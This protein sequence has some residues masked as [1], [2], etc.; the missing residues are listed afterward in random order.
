MDFVDTTA[1]KGK[2]F[3]IKEKIDFFSG[4][5]QGSALLRKITAQLMK[6]WLILTKDKAG[7]LTCFSESPIVSW[8]RRILGVWVFLMPLY[9]AYYAVGIIFKKNPKEFNRSVV[10]VCSGV[11]EMLHRSSSLSYHASKTLISIE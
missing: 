10:F 4:Q 8:R 11:G 7:K 9:I 1:Y 5:K 6:Y 2:R 3:Q